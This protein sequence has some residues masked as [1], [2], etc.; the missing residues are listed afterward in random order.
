MQLIPFVRV[1][2]TVFNNFIISDYGK[3]DFIIIGAGTAGCVIANRLSENP[4]WKV[5]L[6]EPG[7]YRDEE[8]SGMPALWIPDSFS[9]FDWG[10]YSIPQ[11]TACLGKCRSDQQ[12]NWRETYQNQSRN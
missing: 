5:L 11:T 12:H 7:S 4:R 2:Y 1:E 3:F 9:K 8:V 6:L 10:F